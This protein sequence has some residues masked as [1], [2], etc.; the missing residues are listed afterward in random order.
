MRSAQSSPAQGGWRRTVGG[1]SMTQPALG[2]EV[3][4]TAGSSTASP[5]PA[6]LV[7]GGGGGRVSAEEAH[8]QVQAGRR[9]PLTSKLRRMLGHTA[10]ARAGRPHGAAA[11]CSRTARQPQSQHLQESME[12]LAQPSPFP[13]VGQAREPFSTPPTG[14]WVHLAM[15]FCTTSLNCPTQSGY[16]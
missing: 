7:C 10:W 5:G 9:R 15:A 13:K 16:K 11:P 4:A 2:R 14:W 3:G 12:T 6:R 8:S 1:S